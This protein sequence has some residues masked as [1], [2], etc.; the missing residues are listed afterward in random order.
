MTTKR[1]SRSQFAGVRH[2]FLYEVVTFA[3]PDHGK[4]AIRKAMAKVRL[5][6][7]TV[8]LRIDKAHVQQSITAKGVGSTSAC[9]AAIC[10]ARNA[11]AF[12]HQVEGHVD[13]NYYRAF[14]VSKVDKHGLPSECYAYEHN[15]KDIALLN[16]T[17][18]G[19]KRL[20]AMTPIDLV[21][22]PYRVR[23]VIGRPGTH[24]KTGTR[25][26]AIAAKG[27]KLRYQTATVG[28]FPN[29]V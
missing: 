25:T 16:D 19:Q 28:V 7:K 10:M 12:P 15:R 8:T 17:P 22:K 29:A 24:S 11:E 9:V 26:R 2:P 13:F 5:A 27:A 20:L 14:V 23:S 3:G 6:T 4:R 21:L 1:K 18:G